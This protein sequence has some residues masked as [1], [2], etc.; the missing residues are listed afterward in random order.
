[1]KRTTTKEIFIEIERIRITRER[2]VRSKTEAKK[3]AETLN[4]EHPPVKTD[5]LAEHLFKRFF[6]LRDN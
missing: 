1:M 5:A 3:G 6:C 2:S 4:G